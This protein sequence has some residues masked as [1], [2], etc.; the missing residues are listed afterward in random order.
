M[1]IR[2]LIPR[3]GPRQSRLLQT[4]HGTMTAIA[5]MTKL[6]LHFLDFY[7]TITIRL[8]RPNLGLLN[9]FQLK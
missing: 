4:P 5:I 9:L 8:E 2:G 6:C 1:Y 3:N 7:R